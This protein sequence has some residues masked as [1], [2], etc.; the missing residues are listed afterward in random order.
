MK[1]AFFVT[2]FPALS[3]TFVLNQITG[4]I[5]RGHEVTIYARDPD[6]QP[7]VHADVERYDLRR[8]TIYHR[9]FHQTVP[10]NKA[11]GLL[12]AAS[13]L[14]ASPEPQ[15]RP[16]LKS[17]NL[18]EFGPE[19]ASLSLFYRTL[20]FLESGLPQYDIV[21]CHFGPNGNLGALLKRLGAVRGKLITTFHGYDLTTLIKQAGPEQYNALF[22]GGDL[23]LPISRRWQDTLIQLGCPP[24]K[25][26]VH[27]MGVDLDKFQFTPR[28]PDREQIRLLTVAR[29]VEKK[30]VADGIRAVARV[31]AKHPQLTYHIA[32]D[33]PLRDDLQN[34][35]DELG[36]GARIKLLG[37]QSQ[38]KIIE[39]MQQAHIIVAPSVTGAD[40]DQEGIPVVLMEAMAQGLPVLSTRHSGIPELVQDGQ[41]G[42]LAAEHDIDGLAEKLTGLVE[43]PHL[44]PTMGQ[45]GRDY[46][47]NHYNIEK[48]NDQLV[49]LYQQ[50]CLEPPPLASFS[51]PTPISN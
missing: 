48:L 27:R 51:I 12:K 19:A 20:A 10:R 29:L 14:L 26:V 40:G 47:A 37:W 18:F 21:H 7:A 3:Q 1:I 9:P 46:V 13:R 44:W 15:R 4:L 23:F 2:E 24:E 5:D 33:G 30:G 50:V 11:A 22:E 42:F 17:L 32:G 34:L 8:R 43:Q 6:H 28:Q 39:L 36:V 31:A 38:E 35:I 25:I 16:L 45:A 49:L 41:S